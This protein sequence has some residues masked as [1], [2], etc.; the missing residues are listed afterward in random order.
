GVSILN[1]DI[2]KIS[3][4]TKPFSEED[5]QII[6]LRLVK[7]NNAKRRT[8]FVDLGSH[9]YEHEYVLFSQRIEKGSLVFWTI[10]YTPTG[11]AYEFETD[12]IIKRLDILGKMP[13]KDTVCIAFSAGMKCVLQEAEMQKKFGLKN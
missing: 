3:K 12:Q 2:N 1:T 10:I 7:K 4:S 6:Q 13:V 9:K 5:A 8:R 11:T